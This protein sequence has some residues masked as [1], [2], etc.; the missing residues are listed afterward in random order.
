MAGIYTSGAEVA[1]N[2]VRYNWVHGCHPESEQG[3]H[4]GLGVRIDD[5][6]RDFSVHHNVVWDCGLDAIVVKGEYNYVYNNTIRH[7]RP[8]L[9]YANAIRLDTEPEP[10]K[11]WR[12]DHCLLGEQN[13]HTLVFNNVVGLIR[14]ETKRD[15]PFE[16]KSNAIHNALTYSPELVD[17]AQFEFAPRA[18]PTGGPAISHGFRC[19]RATASGT[20]KRLC[21][22]AGGRVRWRRVPS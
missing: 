11:A 20:R 18:G 22:R 4:I 10:Y 8:E 2:V 15:T 6:G 3:K 21:R 19:S 5:Q 9:R 1:G 16:N 14:A 12:R 17:P 13:A 7:L